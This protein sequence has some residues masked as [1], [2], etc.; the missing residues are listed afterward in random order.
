MQNLLL[1][2][3]VGFVFMAWWANS[4]K[5]NMILCRFRRPNKTIISKWVKMKSLYVETPDGKYDIVPSCISLQWYNSGFINMIFPQWIA[6]LDYTYGRRLP[7]NPNT[8]NYEWENPETRKA[9]NKAE[10]IQSYA[11]TSNPKID[12]K[13]DLITKYLPWVAILLVV[14]VGF[15][16]YT[17]MQG[18]AA[19]MQAMQ[20]SLNA[21]T[22]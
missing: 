14:I 16:M 8:M 6:T 17:N 5:K 19:H 11:K 18:L 9:I 7:L 13:Q 20:N 3:A 22:K 21:I 4:S 10:T 1:I 15:W 2:V 12:K